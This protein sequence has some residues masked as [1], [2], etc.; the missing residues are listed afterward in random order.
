MANVKLGVVK[1]KKQG[2]HYALD[3]NE[4]QKQQCQELFSLCD[5]LHNGYIRVEF[6]SPSKLRST[7]KNSQNTHLNGHIQQICEDTGNDFYDVKIKVKEM[8]ISRGYPILY[9]ENGVPKTNLYGVILGISEA[10]CDTY[11]CK[12]LIDCVHQLASELDIILKENV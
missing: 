12:L 5:K 9:D 1:L 11:Q 10:D 8:A 4:P 7:G 3:L 2:Q 6:K